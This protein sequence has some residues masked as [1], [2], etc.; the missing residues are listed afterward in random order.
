MAERTVLEPKN[1]LLNV[2]RSK[3]LPHNP[4]IRVG[5]LVFLSGMVA[6]DPTNGKVRT[7]SVEEETR[8]V[9][10]NMKHMLESAGTGMEHAVKLTVNLSDAAGY[11]DMNRVYREFFG[12]A[13]PPACSVNVVELSF[14]LKIEIEC[15]AVMPE[16]EAK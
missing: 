7:G 2:S 12:G 10:S 9:L 11:A 16:G 8:M 6:V 1:T 13:S 4:G 5:D 14:G 3:N 15:L